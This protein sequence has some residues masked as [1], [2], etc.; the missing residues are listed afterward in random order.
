[1]AKLT[2]S[3]DIGAFLAAANKSAGVDLLGVPL[4]QFGTNANKLAATGL[5]TGT[6]AVIT[7][8]GNRIE[9][10]LSGAANNNANWAVLK[11]TINLNIYNN[12]SSSIAINNVSVGSLEFKNVGWVDPMNIPVGTGARFS[13]GSTQMGLFQYQFPWNAT[14]SYFNAQAGSGTFCIPAPD[15]ATITIPI[16]TY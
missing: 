14:P 9:Q 12:L 5:A 16:F 10:Y 4:K 7:G 2:T 15:R 8:E 6:L 13:F 1:M 11:N 3:Y